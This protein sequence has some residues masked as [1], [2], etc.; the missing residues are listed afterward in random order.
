M[1]ILSAA[2]RRHA[3]VIVMIFVICILIECLICNANAFRLKNNGDYKQKTYTL[4]DLKITNAEVDMDNG[5][6]IYNNTEHSPVF[7]HIN[8]IDTKIGTVYLDLDIPNG[9]LPYTVCYTDETN[10]NFY[11]S[12]EREYVSGV[13]KT[14]WFTCHFRGKSQQLI[15]RLDNLEKEYAFCFNKLQINKP[16]PFQFSF[17]RFIVIFMVLALFYGVRYIAFFH[18]KEK[19][20]VHNVALIGVCFGFIFIAIWIYFH[21]YSDIKLN[22]MYNCDF[23]DALIKGQLHLDIEVSEE[24]KAMENPY[25]TSIRQT[26]HIVC[27]WDTAYYNGK[28]YC[29]YGIV[30]A[31]LFFVPYK[32]LT[33]VYLQCNIVVLI[34]YC[35]Y[36]VFLDLTS[37]KIFRSTMPDISFGLE[38]IALIILN[39]ATSIFYFAAEPSF[40]L[41]LYAVGLLFVAMGF[42]CFTVWYTNRRANWILLFLGGLCLSLA[43]GCRPPLLF[44]S[45]LLI[46]FGIRYLLK[47]PKNWIRD[48]IVLMIPYILVG[49]GLAVY[50]Y[51]RFDSILEFGQTYQLTAQDQLHNTHTIYEIPV[52]LWLGLFQPLQFYA[53]FPFVSSGNPVNNYA[54]NFFVGSGL[55]P[56]LSQ[57]PLL[58]I[59]FMPF[60]WK[61]WF[62]KSELFS[63][64]TLLFITIT[65]AIV[66]LFEFLNAGVEWRYTAEIAPL[67]CIVAVLLVGNTIQ[68]TTQET[69]SVIMSFMY[70]LAVYTFAVSFLRG[71]SGT[72]GYML[73]YHPEFYYAIE[74]TFCFWK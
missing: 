60:A 15:L 13:D 70:I 41:V 51:L 11:R 25:D 62:G 32:L 31:L 14:K 8:N 3:I 47:K 4:Q 6:I 49:S 44:Y 64:I 55:T 72:F 45:L 16:V 63:K 9:V 73:K 10:A 21:S 1:E 74:R 69:V 61:K 30:P 57:V 7:I 40:Y 5:K 68:T 67:L 12:F 18:A 66:M 24:L 56:L 27:S 39:A 23:T 17:M 38:G 54:G 22:L 26:E 28:Y 19:T 48:I 35:L 20:I 59:L 34:A 71:I 43:V 33:G 65:G 42:W 36:L 2:Y 37:I 53:V 46:P 29:Y 52:L 50:N 58:W